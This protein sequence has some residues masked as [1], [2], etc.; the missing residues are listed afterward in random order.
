[1]NIH[2]VLKMYTETINYYKSAIA[3][4][5]MCD[6]GGVAD[7]SSISKIFDA[8]IEMADP[9]DLM[10]G[11]TSKASPTDVMRKII[12]RNQSEWDVIIEQYV[13]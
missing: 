11:Y 6:Y 5:I 9:I 13:G 10:L 8:F 12:N 2:V 3:D 4:L 7:R 1:M